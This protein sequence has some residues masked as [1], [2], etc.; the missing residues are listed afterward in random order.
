MKTRVALLASVLIALSPAVVVA[1]G[2][3]TLEP[4]GVPKPFMNR[5][6]HGKV[7][8]ENARWLYTRYSKWSPP[9]EA[10]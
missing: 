8:P 9:I 1:E 6:S 5:Y 7:V 10:T 2:I 3:V 4:E